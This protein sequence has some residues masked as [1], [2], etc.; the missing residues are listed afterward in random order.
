MNLNE[1]QDFAF[2]EKYKTKQKKTKLYV[3]IIFK[4]QKNSR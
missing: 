1:V 4:Q 2:H 3:R